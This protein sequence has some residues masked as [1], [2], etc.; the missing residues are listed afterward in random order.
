MK[1]LKIRN[2]KIEKPLNTPS[3]TQKKKKK[4]YT[5]EFYEYIF[6]NS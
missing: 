2:D 5:I 3:K 6:L 1:S 4:L